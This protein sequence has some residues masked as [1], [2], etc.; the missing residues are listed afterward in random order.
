MRAAVLW[1]Q[2]DAG[3]YE[4]QS[5]Q[6]SSPVAFIHRFKPHGFALSPREGNIHENQYRKE[7]NVSMPPARGVRNS[8]VKEKF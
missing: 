3:T 5:V 8:R 7:V 2:K 6:S 1:A 4:N